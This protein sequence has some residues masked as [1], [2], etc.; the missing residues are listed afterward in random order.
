M[1][2]NDNRLSLDPSLPPPTKEDLYQELNELLSAFCSEAQQ[3]FCID[4]E[5]ISREEIIQIKNTVQQIQQLLPTMDHHNNHH[6]RQTLT[7]VLKN[8]LHYYEEAMQ[9]RS[10]AFDLND[11]L[12]N[13]YI[14]E[15]HKLNQ[16]LELKKVDHQHLPYL[17]D[18]L[19]SLARLWK[20]SSSSSPHQ[21]QLSSLKQRK[22]QQ[23]QPQSYRF[24]FT[25][26]KRRLPLSTFPFT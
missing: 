4:Q 20:H 1:N 2:Q 6:L 5:I 7:F 18:D 22:Q 19:S 14:S 9:Q 21:L 15:W 13:Q 26:K 24:P 10:M 3:Q 8:I 11:V 23:Q 16:L 12:I 17:L 25:K